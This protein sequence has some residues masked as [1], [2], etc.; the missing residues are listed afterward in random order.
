MTSMPRPARCPAAAAASARPSCDNGRSLLPL[1]RRSGVC[2][3]RPCRSRWVTVVTTGAG[4]VTGWLSSSTTT[5]S[6]ARS[7]RTGLPSMAL[8]ASASAAP[9]C[10]R[11]TQV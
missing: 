5:G 9:F 11:G 8:L 4:S 1:N 7:R 3:V 2:S 6:A 10:A